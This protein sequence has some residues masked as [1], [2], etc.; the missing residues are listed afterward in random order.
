MRG[1]QAGR[2]GMKVAG[3]FSEGQAGRE[4][5][6]QEC[7]VRGRQARTAF[8]PQSQGKGLMRRVFEEYYA[9]RLGWHDACGL[10]CGEQG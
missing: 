6:R 7:S 8:E 1:R 3:V 4:G 2:Q 5:R 10:G 9:C